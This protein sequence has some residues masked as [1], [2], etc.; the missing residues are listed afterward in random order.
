M[1]TTLLL[2]LFG[3]SACA[4]NGTTPHQGR[5]HDHHPEYKRVCYYQRGHHHHGHH[6]RQFCRY[7][8]VDY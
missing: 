5:S 3:L 1:K 6:S 8:R 4:S 2:I 7:M